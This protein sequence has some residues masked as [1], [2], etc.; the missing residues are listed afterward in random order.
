MNKTRSDSPQR[1]TVAFSTVYRK[2]VP[3]QAWL[4]EAVR[5]TATHLY[6]ELLEEGRGKRSSYPRGIHW[7]AISGYVSRAFGALVD[8]TLPQF[9]PSLIMDLLDRLEDLAHIEQGYCIPRE[10]RVVRLNASWGR[11]AG[12]LP[13]EF[14]EHPDKSVR[15]VLHE[16]I[17]RIALLADYNEGDIGEEHSE[18][19]TWSAMN[20]EKIFSLLSETLPERMSTQPDEGTVTFYNCQSTYARVR[21]DRWQ[22]KAVRDEFVV[23]RT[24]GPAT[25]YFVCFADGTRS[26]FRWFEVDKDEGRKWVL[27]AEMRSSVQNVIRRQFIEKQTLF[28]LPDMLPTAW[29]RDVIACSSTCV[30]VD[31]GWELGVLEES[32]PLLEL[33][34]KSANIRLI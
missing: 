34:L 32:L 3:T 21:S 27:L 33:L 28:R 24:T 18:V 20:H 4:T 10:S 2:W 19:F 31:R 16:T 7:A 17:G 14:S 23:A 22:N 26:G 29:T 12:G 5:A 15:S 30:R 11:I 1:A 9:S 8:D 6:S 25:H 13:L